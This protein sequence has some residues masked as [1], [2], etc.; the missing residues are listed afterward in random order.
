LKQVDQ[1][2]RRMRTDY[3]DLFQLHRFDPDTPL[4]ETLRTLD[5]LVTSGKVRYVGASNFQAWQLMKGLSIQDRH[6]YARFISIQPGYSLADR[7]V[8]QELVPCLLDQGIGLIA[9]FPLAGG[10]LTGK[11]RA[12]E[13]P[14]EGSRAVT[15]PR[16]A[17]RLKDDQLMKLAEGVAAL[18]RELDVTPSQ[19]SLAWL[20]HQPTMASAISGATRPDQVV[21]N[22]GAVAVPWSDEV[23]TRLE[24]LSAPFRHRR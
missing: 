7:A 17:D 9:Y 5:D 16:F 18:A 21:D 8:E 1:S 12:G 15:T 6:G 23:A 10:V 3:I 20:L 13:A 14:P 22:A 4:E 24:E 11:Y 2:L 19:L